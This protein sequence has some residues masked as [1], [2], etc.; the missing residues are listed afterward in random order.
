MPRCRSLRTVKADSLIGGGDVEACE[1]G[2][3]IGPISKS[4]DFE[5]IKHSLTEF[6]MDVSSWLQDLGWLQ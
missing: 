1:V 2:G 3:A 5:K 6:L 4:V